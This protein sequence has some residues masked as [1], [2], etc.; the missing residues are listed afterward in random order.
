MDVLTQSAWRA[1]AR[2]TIAMAALLFISAGTLRYW[3]AWA[4]LACFVVPTAWI[5]RWLIR[6]DRELLARRLEAGVRAEKVATQKVIMALGGAAFVAELVLPGL[7]FRFGH[8]PLGTLATIGG[9]ALVLTGFAIVWRVYQ[10]NSH[11]A[12][13]VR[14]EQGQPL[15]SSGPYACVRH[16]MYAGVAA[17]IVGI[18][19]ALAFPAGFYAAGALLVLLVLRTLDEE[20]HLVKEL[21]GYAEYRQAVRYRLIPLLW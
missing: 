10:V 3:Q 7:S 21:P 18:P 17:C 11:T 2:M 4:F 13:T 6:N 12:A 19:L 15:V 5:T 16:P 9:D 20:R 1:V 14:V 8:P